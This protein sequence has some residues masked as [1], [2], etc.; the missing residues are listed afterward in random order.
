M[1]NF[2]KFLGFEETG[3]VDQNLFDIF[4]KRLSNAFKEDLFATSI[5]EAIIK[6]A[7]LHVEN[8]PRELVIRG[9]SNCGPWVRAY[10]DGK[11]G[12]SYKWCMG[13]VQTI[14]DQALSLFGKNI[15]AF[16]PLT[17]SCDTIGMHGIHNNKLL[18]YADARKNPSLIQEGDLFLI[19]KSKFDWMHTGIV[20]AVNGETITTIEGNTNF[21][22]SAN[23]EAVLRRIRNFKKS[24]IDFYQ[25]NL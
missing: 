12:E 6:V 3:I 5:R 1:K 17:Y 23:G 21:A 14:I 15:K 4:T 16:M 24:K 7:E 11:D 13:F 20:A 18:R 8:F 19:Q 9:N 10:M 25:L 22:G 2:Q